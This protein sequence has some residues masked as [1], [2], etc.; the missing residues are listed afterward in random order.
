MQ[1][2]K[3]F[4]QA[5]KAPPLVCIRRAVQSLS[6]KEEEEEQVVLVFSF[7]LG[8]H[9]PRISEGIDPSKQGGSGGES[10]L[11]YVLHWPGARQR[12]LSDRDCSRRLLRAHVIQQQSIQLLRLCPEDCF[13]DG[14]E[15]SLSTFLIWPPLPF[16]GAAVLEFPLG[17]IGLCCPDVHNAMVLLFGFPDVHGKWTGK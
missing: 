11:L 15:R 5:L 8:P 1:I 13:A 3:D 12:E 10:P 7:E 17:V 14:K 9:A 16:C 4:S 6:L 2:A